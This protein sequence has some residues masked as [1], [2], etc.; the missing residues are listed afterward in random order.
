MAKAKLWEKISKTVVDGVT[1]AAE[2]TEEY[3]RLGRAKI[4]VLSVKRKVTKNFTELGGI[5]YDA[6]KSGQTGEIFES[7]EVVVLI[8]SLK[9]LDKE[10]EEKEALF[11]EMKKK[12]DTE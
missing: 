2:K 7:P 4:D 10:L 6:A 5:I 9:A 11:E 8:D 1:T 3:T 12:T